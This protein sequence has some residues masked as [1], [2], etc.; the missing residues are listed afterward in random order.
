MISIKTVNVIEKKGNEII[1]SPGAD[2][3]NDDWLRTARLQEKADNGDAKAQEEID[4]L[5]SE[6]ILM[7]SK[8]EI[9]EDIEEQKDNKTK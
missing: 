8:E 3:G 6:P 4:K 1:F 5:Y 2:A 7:F 9:L